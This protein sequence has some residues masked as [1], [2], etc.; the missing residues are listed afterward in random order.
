M[1]LF[2]RD[3]GTQIRLDD[4]LSRLD[5][6]DPPTQHKDIHAIMLNTL[7]SGIGIVA[8]GGQRPPD[9]VGGDPG[10]NSTATEDDAPFSPTLDD[11]FGNG[12]PEIRIVITGI[13]LKSANVDDFVSMIKQPQPDRLF[14]IIS[15]VIGSN[16]H[17]HR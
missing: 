10:T 14:Q 2:V 13:V 12:L 5:T 7:M 8:D 1:A 9:L 3:Y 6:N 17:F 4:L 16:N 15:S 11:S